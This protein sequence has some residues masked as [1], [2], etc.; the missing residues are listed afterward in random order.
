MKLRFGLEAAISCPTLR[1]DNS[2]AKMTVQELSVQLK[3]LN[4][5]FVCHK[6]VDETCLE[7]KGKFAGLHLTDKGVG[8]MAINFI[9][10][11]RKN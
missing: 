4:I 5:S 10:Y 3:A 9:S 7:K 8:R 2:K 6:N 11:N 1:T